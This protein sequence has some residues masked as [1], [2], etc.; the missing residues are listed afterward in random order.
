MCV[1]TTPGINM[2]SLGF[3]NAALASADRCMRGHAPTCP[4]SVCKSLPR[5]FS[6]INLGGAHPAFIPWAGDRFRLLEG[7]FRDELQ[8]LGPQWCQ[9]PLRRH[10]LLL[11]EG[12]RSLRDQRRAQKGQGRCQ[13]KPRPHLPSPALVKQKDSSSSRQK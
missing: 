8:R 10:R 2:S 13:G 1:L 4:C 5:V 6:L 3:C 9:S 7:E 11:L 12:L